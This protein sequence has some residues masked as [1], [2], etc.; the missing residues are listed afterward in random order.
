MRQ[1]LKMNLF[2][3]SFLGASHGQHEQIPGA[4]W[5]QLGIKKKPQRQT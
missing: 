2:R 3:D 1:L 4:D 5:E